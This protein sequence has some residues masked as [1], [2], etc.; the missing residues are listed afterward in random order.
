MLVVPQKI[1]VYL[2]SDC[3]GTFGTCGYFAVSP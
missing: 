2:L 3:Y 1:V